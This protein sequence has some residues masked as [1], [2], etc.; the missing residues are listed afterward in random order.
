[1]N[2]IFIH[3]GKN[4][5]GDMGASYLASGLASNKNPFTKL[6]VRSC[7]ITKIGGLQIV[8]SLTYDRGLHTLEIDNNQ[9]SLEVIIALHEMFKTNFIISQLSIHNCNFPEKISNFLRRVAFYNRY[10]KRSEFTYINIKDLYNN[11][12]EKET[13]ENIKQ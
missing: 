13:S 4:N 7:N 10:H 5:I 3:L 8:Q 11:I 6:S 9:L 12:E 1:M 2:K